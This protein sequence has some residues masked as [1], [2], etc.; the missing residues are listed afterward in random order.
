MH[1]YIYSLYRATYNYIYSCISAVSSIRCLKTEA[2]LSGEVSEAGNKSL[3]TPRPSAKLLPKLKE[4]LP[5]GSAKLMHINVSY[6]IIIITLSATH[7]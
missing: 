6:F 2:K 4:E 5:K 3:S 7:A 1:I